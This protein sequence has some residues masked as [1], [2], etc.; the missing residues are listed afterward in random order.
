MKNKNFR[1]RTMVKFEIPSWFNER[2]LLRCDGSTSYEI[3]YIL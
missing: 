3:P 2:T 1:L